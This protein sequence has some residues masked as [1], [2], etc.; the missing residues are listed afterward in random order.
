M[1]G[2]SPAQRARGVLTDLAAGLFSGLFSENGWLKFLSFFV[3]VSLW[4]VLQRDQEV[5][6]R[7]RAQV[8]YTFPDDLVLA[9][10]IVTSAMINV[11]GPQAVVRTLDERQLF[12]SV[13]LSD[14]PE[15]ATA[16]DF[17][18]RPVRGLPSGVQVVQVAPVGTQ[19]EL[20]QALS[21]K[22]VVRPAV[23]GNVASGYRKT[24]IRV[25]P[26]VLEISGPQGLVKNIAEVST[27]VID[28]NNLDETRSF[29]VPLAIERR[30]VRPTSQAPVTITVEV[31]PILRERTFAQVKVVER[32]PGWQADPSE[33]RV[34]L[35]GPEA[36]L[37]GISPSA[38]SV[39]LHLPVPTTVGE[40]IELQWKTE[41]DYAD[42]DGGVQVVLPGGLRDV[43]VV[44]VQPDRF[45]LAPLGA[46]A[47]DIPVSPTPQDEPTP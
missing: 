4:A 14:A 10:D 3:A 30:T 8:N 17:T 41:D 26:P 40:P 18:D 20:D 15:G 7:A 32:A 46:V 5:M 43:S 34:V 28:I 33:A 1:A 6:E 11:R 23:I 21:R 42:A 31:E 29:E 37:K 39:L 45:S 36:M 35:A 24:A 2:P 47:P 16:V 13:D 44:S 27:D 25:E 12:I 9:N 22:V 19:V 38:L